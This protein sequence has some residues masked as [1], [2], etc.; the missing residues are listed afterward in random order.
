MDT[1]FEK[2]QAD[3]KKL[4]DELPSTKRPP[5]NRPPLSQL[6][7]KLA[8]KKP[9][10]VM[11]TIASVLLISRLWSLFNGYSPAEE[12][13]MFS[14]VKMQSV[15]LKE[16]GGE[17]LLYIGPTLRPAPRSNQILVR[18]SAFGINRNDLLQR[19][20][21][22]LTSGQSNSILGI[23]FSGIVS[24]VGSKVRKFKTGQRVSGITLGGSYAEYVVADE[25][26]AFHLPTSLTTEQGAAIPEV[27]L[28]SYKALYSIGNIQKDQSV[29][30]HGGAGGLGSVAIQMSRMA[31]LKKILAT[32][33][34]QEK[35]KHCE[36]MGATKVINYRTEDFED[37]VL[38][39]TGGE[40]VD[41]IIDV[42]GGDF[43]NKNLNSLK[44]GGKIIIL[45]T[46]SGA[47]VYES[48]IGT[49]LRKQLRV[50]GFDLKATP[51]PDLVALFKDFQT[52]IL[53]AISRKTIRPIIDRT[54]SW[55]EI[56]EAHQYLEEG[57]NKGKIV[58]VIE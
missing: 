47:E 55:V 57:S 14:K 25:N 41:L 53:P 50:E 37:S 48:N 22:Y 31:G 26:L 11:A 43:W 36:R 58:A 17:S 34:S 7:F 8:Q 2:I 21:K 54:F 40:G 33:S 45:G 24:E 29:L 38:K 56:A 51:K 49:I 30:I 19:E 35:I 6:L 15:L 5:V 16:A 27:F 20:E 13:T 32:T 10:Y 3:L 18:V 9:T 1:A 44:V 42:V 4:Q 39:E 23:E 52:K 46:L 12:S 28:V